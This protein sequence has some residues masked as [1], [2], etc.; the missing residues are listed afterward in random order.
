MGDPGHTMHLLCY[1]LLSCCCAHWKEIVPLLK[2]L[3]TKFKTI[4]LC[5]TSDAISYLGFKTVNVYLRS[6]I[7]RTRGLVGKNKGKANVSVYD[8]SV[9]P[10]GF[11]ESIQKNLK[12]QGTQ[13]TI[14]FTIS[15]NAVDLVWQSFKD[16]TY[17]HNIILRL[18]K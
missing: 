7:L 6:Y 5:L 18:S 17:V 14:A 12:W 11:L 8:G 4:F 15:N 3:E 9:F 10:L 1:L 16:V 2:I 13:D